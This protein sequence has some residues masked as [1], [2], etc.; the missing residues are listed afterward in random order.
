MMS[1]AATPPVTMTTTRAC[2]DA[3]ILSTTPTIVIDDES[4]VEGYEEEEEGEAPPRRLSQHLTLRKKSSYRLVTASVVCSTTGNRKS[5]DC[6]TSVTRF[7]YLRIL[8]VMAVVS[9]VYC[10]CVVIVS[11]CVELL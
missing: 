9:I 7:R 10:H 5:C 6:S 3:S 4:D 2:D 8:E 11:I 1:E